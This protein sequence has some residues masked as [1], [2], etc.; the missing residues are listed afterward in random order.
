MHGCVPVIRLGVHTMKIE[1]VDEMTYDDGQSLRGDPAALVPGV[2]R[3]SEL[4]GCW[5]GVEELDGAVAAE[6]AGDTILD[7]E[8]HPFAWPS[9]RDALLLGVEPLRIGHRVGGGPRLVEG[10]LWPGAVGDEGR[11]VVS[12]ERPQAQPRGQELHAC[13]IRPGRRAARRS[14]REAA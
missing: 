3:H 8:L 2:E 9:E 10:E 7:G 6:R 11:Q 13:G 5:L 1:V 12:G 14:T 4:G